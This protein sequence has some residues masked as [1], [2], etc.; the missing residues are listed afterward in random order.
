MLTSDELAEFD[1]RGLVRVR[2]A[3]DAGAA[4]A[5][6]EVV[7]REIERLHGIRR[8]APATWHPSRPTGLQGI[9]EDPVFAAIGS[10][11]TCTAID[12]LLGA[13][14]WTLPRHWGFLLVSFAETDTWTVPSAGWHFDA[15]TAVAPRP[16]FGVRVYA[17]L[18]DVVPEGGGTVVAHPWLLHARAPHRAATPRLVRSKDVFRRDLPAGVKVFGRAVKSPA[19]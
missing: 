1:A 5:M 12:A 7:W 15:D 8:D 16:L 3:F 18:S 14:T 19:T 2:G 17:F 10:R 4:A 6:R 9:K 11:A 13:G